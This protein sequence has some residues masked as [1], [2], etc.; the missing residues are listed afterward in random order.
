IRETLEPIG[1]EGGYMRD[2][3]GRRLVRA[4]GAT[5]P[6]AAGLMPVQRPVGAAKSVIQDLIGF[7]TSVE[8]D[9][10]KM[11]AKTASGLKQSDAFVLNGRTS[12]AKEFADAG[13]SNKAMTWWDEY[14]LPIADDIRKYVDPRVGGRFEKAAETATRYEAGLGKVMIEP[15]EDVITA[16]SKDREVKRALMD[17]HLGGIDGVSNARAVFRSKMGSEGVKKFDQWINMTRKFNERIGKTLFFD[18]AKMADDVYIH[19]EKLA[20]RKAKDTASS[21]K[22]RGHASST[23][24]SAL[25][26]RTRKPAWKMTDAEVD[27][28]MNPMLAHAKYVSDMEHLVRQAKEFNVKPVMKTGSSSSTFFEQGMKKALTRKGLDADRAT[29]AQDLMHKHYVGMRSAPNPFVRSLMSLGYA[30]TL[31]QLKTASLNLADVFVSMSQQGVRPTMKAVVSGT[32]GEFGKNL[33][34]L[35]L[36]S[37]HNVGE[38]VRNFDKYMESP[39]AMQR[40]ARGSHKVSDVAMSVSGFKLL[41]RTGKGVI[42]R[43]SMNMARKS[44]KEGTLVKNF[45][46]VMTPSQLKKLKP[47]L[48]QGTKAK[49]MPPKVMKLAEQLAFT[50]LGKQQL[51]STVGRPLAY[52]NNPTIRPAYAMTGFA[53]KQLALVRRNFFGAMKE[54]RPAEAA[55]WGAA[56]V[57]YAAFGTAA[58]NEGRSALFKNDEFHTE[59]LVIGTLEHMASVGTMNKLGDPYSVEKFKGDPVGTVVESLLPPLGLTVAASKDASALIFGGKYNAELVKKAPL[60]GDFYK[61][62]WADQTRSEKERAKSNYERYQELLKRD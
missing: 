39:S 13:G 52:L 38:F 43:A 1:I 8:D 53:I 47:Y 18:H 50:Q 56:Y 42:L 2:N 48:E 29:A 59:D 37:S 3:I 45:G 36:D 12:K 61:Y 57:A 21:L 23:T 6:A 58:L 27:E 28:Y 7:G 35:G 32:K 34:G 20:G 46:D 11:A 25:K 41:D 14:T 62:Y 26:D 15:Y 4:A 9:V 22:S 33:S 31:A 30:G 54:G 5:V 44:A 55:K 24:P 51:I 19:T 16:A 49:D 17:I 40:F 10:A 60:L